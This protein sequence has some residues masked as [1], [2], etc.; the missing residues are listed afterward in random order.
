[1]AQD[2]PLGREFAVVGGV[3][4]EVDLCTR[5][6][7]IRLRIEIDEME[8]DRVLGAATGSSHLPSRSGELSCDERP[9]DALGSDDQDSAC[10]KGDDDSAV[11]NLQSV[12]LPDLT[13]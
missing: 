9:Q 6:A 1:V 10:H 7:Q 3:D 2:G 12:V 5:L 11:P 13:T 8:V 4:N